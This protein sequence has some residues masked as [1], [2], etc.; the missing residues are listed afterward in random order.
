MASQ[1]N[2]QRYSDPDYQAAHNETYAHPLD[3]DIPEVLPPSITRQEFDDAMR[4]CA[5]ALGKGSTIFTGADRK[6]F[7][8]PYDLPEEGRERRIPS[9]AVW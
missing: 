4:K 5:E 3:S 2:P 9:A 7:I 6:E 1:E 8:D